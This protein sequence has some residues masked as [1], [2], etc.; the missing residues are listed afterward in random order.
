MELAARHLHKVYGTSV[1][2][3][4]ISFVLEKGQKVGLIGNNGTGKSTL[5]KII[6]GVIDADHG[7]VE[8]RKG[9]TVGYMPQDTSLVTAET[10]REYVRRVSG[11]AALEARMDDS[12]AAHDAFERRRGYSFDNRIEAMLAGFGLGGIA[13]T[14]PITQLSSGQKSKVFMMGVLLAD[15][16]V[17]LLDEPTNNLDL[18]AL[19]WLEDFLVRTEMA[20]II[21]SHDRVFLD[22]VVRKIF[23]I[24]WRART[25][26]ET[27][28]RYSD[29]LA[30]KE[31]EYVAQWHAFESQQ[32]DI[33]RLLSA[34]RMK[35]EAEGRGARARV[36]DNEK[37]ARGARRN[38]ASASVRTARIIEERVARMEKVE[39]PFERD[40][41]RIRLQ[42]EKREGS[43]DIVL[44][45]V[46]AGYPGS[47]FR[48]G[49]LSATI[50]YGDRVAIM[51]LNGS[52]KS[53]L[54]KTISGELSPKGGEIVID[55][56]LVVGN[57]MQEHD[58]LPRK[59]SIHDF[60]MRRAGIVA[61]DAY[62]LAALFGF[63]AEDTHKEI[64]ALSPGERARVL[65]ALF[66]SLSVNVLL[67]DEPTNHL[68]LEALS[69]LEEMLAHYQGTVILVSHD[70][71]F[72]QKFNATD[73][74]TL[75][76]GKLARVENFDAYIRNA[77]REAKRI[78]K[79]L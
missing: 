21:I 77:E 75:S 52:G 46:V 68:D 42:S 11:I 66:S 16:D 48:I 28:G 10:I 30:R 51:G 69:A 35:R 60:L 39:K 8:I 72:L 37:L 57:L 45:K 27:N 17:L 5:L 58:N 63:R 53:T 19:I 32:K 61:E 23:E 6:A 71:Y 78:M 33:K 24:D 79:M 70:R 29:Y 40:L 55:R 1:I 12:A 31:R 7:V 67:L 2:L 76:E 14:R 59:E 62:A 43:R 15:P 36:S 50:A 38:R 64:A 74:F 4:D 47:E 18:P 34:A 54:L 56:A 3:D 73:V 25:L 20:C 49:P 41:F 26:I 9:V 65:F 13:L 22:R 44:S